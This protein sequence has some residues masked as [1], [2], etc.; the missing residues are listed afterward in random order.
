MS[1]IA[2]LQSFLLPYKQFII[3]L[4]TLPSNNSSITI[5]FFNGLFVY[6]P[7]FARNSLALRAN[8]GFNNSFYGLVVVTQ[9][10]FFGDFQR[11]RPF[12]G[13]V[14][15]VQIQRDWKL[16]ETAEDIDCGG[17]LISLAV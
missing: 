5:S 11:K 2:K 7:L 12:Y 8:W 14:I 4:D 16:R 17:E 1:Q 13:L 9:I 10:Q 3:S 6:L 15:L